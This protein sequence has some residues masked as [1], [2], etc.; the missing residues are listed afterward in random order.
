M[1]K[2]KARGK[3]A[4]AKKAPAKQVESESVQATLSERSCTGVLASR[5]DSRD[6][7]IE[8]FSLSYYGI[9]LV[10][11]SIIELNYGRRYGLIGFNGSGKS[12]FLQALAAREVPIP[13]HIDISLLH[14]EAAPS[15]KS[16]LEVVIEEAEKEVTRLEKEETRV[17]DT[18]GPD[19]PLL[20][21]IYER[22]DELSPQ[23]FEKR[24]GEILHGLGFSKVMMSKKTKDLSGGWRMRVALARILFVKPTLMLLDEPTNHLDLETCVWLEDHLK[25]YNH[26]LVI[27][28]HSQDFLN[29]VCTNI[30]HLHRKQIK[31]YGGSYDTYVKTRQEQEAQQMKHYEKQ[32]AD[33][34]HIK[35]FIASC[36]TYANLVKQG[37]SKQKIIDKMEAAGLVEK[38]IA[39]PVLSYT[40]PS[41]GPLAPPVLQFVDVAFAYPTRPNEFLY[42][43]LNIGVDLDSRVALVGANGTGKSTLLKLMDGEIMP[44]KGQV[45]RHNHLQIARYHQH[46][47]DQLNFELSPLETLKSTFSHIQKEEEQWRAV[48]G[49][50]G[51]T[52]S[53]QVTPLKQLSGGQLSRLIFAILAQKVPH[54]LLLDEPTNHLD[55]E[56]IDSLAAAINNFEGGMVLVS[57][58]FRLIDQVA[59]EIWVCHNKTITKWQGDI[60]SYK[61]ALRES[62]EK[63]QD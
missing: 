61:A 21:D 10:S 7:K 57:H 2:S 60:R 55:M 42:E 22:L 39:D 12:T 23:T 13:D 5:K 1:G 33:I 8:N 6:I 40:F 54:L 15:E 63:Y 49:R 53:S 47:A 38:V 16:A 25:T 37:K 27:V 9:E 45:K 18:E 34:A 36:G 30:M 4:A 29:G 17:M 32:Q 19:S 35:Q 14:R 46:A 31:Y 20:Q 26:T 11:D 3:K 24:A 44:I 62:M 58:D 28:S 41:C 48:L 51:L 43:R 52:G 50:Y 59:K 56:S